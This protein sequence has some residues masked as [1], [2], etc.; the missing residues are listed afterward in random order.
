L[1]NLYT[2]S[3]CRVLLSNSTEIT[4]KNSAKP[5]YSYAQL[6]AQAIMSTPDKQIT[7]SGIYSFI[8]QKYPWYQTCD[9]GWQNSIRHNLSLSRYFIKVFFTTAFCY[10]MNMQ[11]VFLW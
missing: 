2:L 4:S 1:Y 9:R 6:I 5:P 11:V 10:G 7:L 3:I 8:I